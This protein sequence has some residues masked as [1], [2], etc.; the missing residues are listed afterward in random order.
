MLVGEGG[1]GV[2][3][4]FL[5]LLNFIITAKRRSVSVASQASNV[6]Y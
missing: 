4:Q 1:S 3:L 5:I 6:L 2:A